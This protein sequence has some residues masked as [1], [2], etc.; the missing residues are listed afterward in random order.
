ML[1]FGEEEALRNIGFGRKRKERKEK[2][3]RRLMRSL[4]PPGKLSLAPDI[5]TCT[6]NPERHGKTTEKAVNL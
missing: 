2:M 4:T 5:H 1:A 6:H 3:K